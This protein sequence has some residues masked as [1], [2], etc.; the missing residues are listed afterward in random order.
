MKVKILQ[1]VLTLK[2]KK[3]WSLEDLSSIIFQL[4]SRLQ[5]WDT[6]GQDRYRSIARSYYRNANLILLCFDLTKQDTFTKLDEWL[7]DIKEHGE[8]GVKLFIVGN[9]LDLT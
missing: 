6:A 4:K 9:K 1:L 8:E 3:K 5:I 2:R 7:N